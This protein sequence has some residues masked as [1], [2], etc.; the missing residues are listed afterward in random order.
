MYY[1]MYSLFQIIS[2]LYIYIWV[3]Y[4]ISLTWIKAIWG[5]F[6]LLTMIPV[7]SQ[8]GRY[9]LTRYI[10]Y[11]NIKFL[12]LSPTFSDTRRL[13]ASFVAVHPS[14]ARLQLR[15]LR[16]FARAA[17]EQTAH[18]QLLGKKTITITTINNMLSIVTNGIIIII[19]MLYVS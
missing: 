6:P 5:W 18:R 13:R 11:S 1:A 10:S 4:N 9:N 3:N 19:N 2:P 7:R 16:V 8:W 17:V 15:R 12:G 14:L